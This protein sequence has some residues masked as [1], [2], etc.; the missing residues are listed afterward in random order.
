MENNELLKIIVFL[1]PFI[2]TGFIQIAWLKAPVCQWMKYPLDFNMKLRGRRIFGNHKTFRGFVLFLPFTGLF[3][4][5]STSIEELSPYQFDI[6]SKGN[7]FLTGV[8]LGLAY[9]LGEL[10]NSFIKRQLD[11]SEGTTAQGTAT[12]F[13]CIVMDQIDSVAATVVAL[14]IV[15]HITLLQGISLII[16]G[17]LIHQLFNVLLYL[18]KVKKHPY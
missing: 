10:P 7:A 5:L 12:K 18:L 4:W 9:M 13:L 3:F 16:A 11:I 8:Y 6:F 2:L 1:M 15:E 14:A 17:G